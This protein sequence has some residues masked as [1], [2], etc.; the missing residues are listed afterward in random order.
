M[1]RVGDED[2]VT[3]SESIDSGTD[4]EG[5][6]CGEGFCD[7]KVIYDG[8]ANWSAHKRGDKWW[9]GVEVRGRSNGIGGWVEDVDTSLPSTRRG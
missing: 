1:D 8:R 3:W 7:G 2:Q 4:H 5:V 9:K 6:R